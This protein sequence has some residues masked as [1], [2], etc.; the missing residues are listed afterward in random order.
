M[1]FT[2]E[3]KNVFFKYSGISG[4]DKNVLENVSLKLSK[5]ECIAILGPSGS[6][7]TTLI[8]HFTGLLKPVSGHVYF[9]GRDIWTKKFPFKELRRKI[10]LVFQFPESQL[11]EETV[12]KDIAYGPQKLGFTDS[13]IQNRARNAMQA[14][15]LDFDFFSHRSP[16]KL[17]EGEKR[18]VAIAGILAMNPGMVVFDEPTAGLDPGGIRRFEEIVNKLLNYG[19]SV[20]LI[21][22]NMDFVALI[23]QRV[24]LM[25]KGRILFDGRPIDLFNNSELMK[26]SGLEVPG[27]ISFLKNLKKPL[28]ETINRSGGLDELLKRV[29]KINH[30]LLE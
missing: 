20:V 24:I 4:S 5:S 23:A 28:P 19:T 25:V 6:G 11:F 10:G 21:T 13:E 12:F 1:D 22:H 2:L 15:G 17:S 8:Q 26:V 9:N 14:V 30:D 27:V 3:L 29:K 7:K 18:R 16:F